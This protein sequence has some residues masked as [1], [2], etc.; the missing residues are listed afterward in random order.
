MDTVSDNPLKRFSTFWLGLFLFGAFGAFCL[1]LGPY[2]KS[3]KKD[4][5]YRAAADKRLAMK[6]EMEAAQAEALKVDPVTVFAKTGADLL[7]V[8]PGPVRD[9]AQVVPGS[10]RAE[11]LAA[12]PSETVE[13]KENDPDAPLDPAVMEMGKG[14]YILCQACHGPNG[15][16][17]PNLAPP[18]ANSE[19]VNGPAVNLIRIQLRGLMGPITVNG[20]EY[21]FAAPMVAQA[22]QTD[23]QIAAVLTYVRN[24][25]GN[26]ASA[27]TP[28]QV[29]ALRGEVGKPPLT[30]EDLVP[31]TT[32]P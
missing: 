32:Q 25:F 2:L 13:I 8:A 11:A 17:I 21:E 5:A 3:E 12:L 18:L 20:T 6:A 27:V 15:E 24:S 14:Q 23:E 19:W 22:F 7:S 28:D 29:K 16:G 26:K 1:V 30:V 9:N 4:P 10:A 31:P